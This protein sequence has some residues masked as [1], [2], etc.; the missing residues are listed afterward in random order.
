MISGFRLEVDEI[1]ALP[2]VTATHR[3]ISQKSTISSRKYVQ[4]EPSCSTRTEEWT[5]RRWI[6]RDV[7]TLNVVFH[8]SVHVPKNGV[9]RAGLRNT[10]F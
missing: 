1:C 3:V 2:A 8:N 10:Q 7:T 4:R 6:N 9:I 5:D